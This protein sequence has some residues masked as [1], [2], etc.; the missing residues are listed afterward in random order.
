V[1]NFSGKASR[2]KISREKIF[3]GAC[4]FKNPMAAGYY[5][6]LV[7]SAGWHSCGSRAEKG[8]K[9]RHHTEKMEEKF[10]TLVFFH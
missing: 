5:G 10:A 8:K 1:R 4:F 6:A 7:N 3:C 2:E 9:R